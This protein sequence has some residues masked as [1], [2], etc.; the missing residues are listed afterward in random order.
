MEASFG[1]L[2]PKLIAN[3]RHYDLDDASTSQE[4]LAIPTVSL[5]SGLYLD[6]PF[7]LSGYNFTQTLEPRI[8][9]TYT[10]YEDQSDIPYFDTSLNELNTTTIFQ[11]N[12][13]SGQDRVMDTNA[14]TT[15]L[16]TR[17]I[18]DSGYDWM[19]LTMGQRFYLS[20]REGIRRGSIC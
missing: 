6:R 9:Y 13:F 16:T 5:D 3:L 1:F 17:I 2:K 4:S 10:P 12:Q 19:L 15:A 14:I 20:D 11:E 8:F 18:D 7:K